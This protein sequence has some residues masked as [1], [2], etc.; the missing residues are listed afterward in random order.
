[1]DVHL[2]YALP[3][4]CYDLK[5]KQNERG[6]MS[7]EQSH[8]HHGNRL[9]YIVWFALLILTILE[10]FLAYQSVGLVM[11]LAI[12]VG[13]SVGKTGLIVAYF[14]HLRYE[15]LS[16]TLTLIPALVF[17]IVM[18]FVIF[19]DSLRVLELQ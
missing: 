7:T 1:M 10:V 12:L 9:Y 18:M 19:P 3:A 15:K 6:N 2:P 13:L 5:A 17:C 11:M 4:V 14:M 16:L 8:E